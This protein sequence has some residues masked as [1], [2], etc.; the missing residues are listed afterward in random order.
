[1]IFARND[2]GGSNFDLCIAKIGE[3]LRSL[4]KQA[5]VAGQAEKL[6]REASAR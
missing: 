1:M 2:D 5:F 6:L 4:L 3:P